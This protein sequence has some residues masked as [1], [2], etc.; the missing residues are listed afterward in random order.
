MLIYATNPLEI[1]DIENVVGTAVFALELAIGLLFGFDLFQ[2]N[3]LGGITGAAAR[4]A[5]SQAGL[6]PSG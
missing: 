1:A 4:V 3:D 6:V 5:T 2:G